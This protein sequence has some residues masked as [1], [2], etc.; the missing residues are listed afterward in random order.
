MGARGFKGAW[1]IIKRSEGKKKNSLEY[2]TGQSHKSPS[3]ARSSSSCFFPPP[4]L[5]RSPSLS[6]SRPLPRSLAVRGEARKGGGG[7]GTFHVVLTRPIYYIRAAQ[8]EG[9]AA[10]TQRLPRSPLGRP[11]YVSEELSRSTMSAGPNSPPFGT[12]T[13]PHK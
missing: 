3:T 13:G 11:H 1:L 8:S 6:C 4:L 9:G 7:V 12:P 2:S 5:P 10:T